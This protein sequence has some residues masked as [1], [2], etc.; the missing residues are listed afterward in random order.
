MGG[1]VLCGGPWLF[2][3]P[4]PWLP[5]CTEDDG[6]PKPEVLGVHGIPLDDAALGMVCMDARNAS[7]SCFDRADAIPLL[8]YIRFCRIFEGDT[9]LKGS[10]LMVNGD[11]VFPG[12]LD[13]VVELVVDG[14]GAEPNG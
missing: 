6:V 3:P 13:P 7:R 14:D 12:V 9:M 1:P 2:L 4:L 10:L 5:E 8:K 11:A